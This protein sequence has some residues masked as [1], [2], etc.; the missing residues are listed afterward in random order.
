[1]VFRTLMNASPQWLAFFM[2]Y[3]SHTTARG[4]AFRILN[5]GLQCY[6]DSLVYIDRNF[7]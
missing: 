7:R 5:K 2:D 6:Y 3:I 4:T 1:M